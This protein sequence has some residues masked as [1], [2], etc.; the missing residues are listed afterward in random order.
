MD[1]KVELFVPCFIDQLYP[2][3]A[4]NTI[5][6]LERVGCEVIYNSEQTC[7][8]QP[9][10]NAGF[11]DEAKEVG[12][13]FL[14]KFTEENYIVAPSA[15]CVG[16][17]KKGYNDLFT[18]SIEHNRCRNIQRHVYEISDFLVNVIKRDY[19]G[20][21]LVGTAVY[22]DSC[23]ALRDCGIK[24]EPRKLLAQVGGLELVEMKGQET[25]CGFGGTFAVK[26]EGISTAMAEQKV[27]NAQAVNADYIIS[28][29]ASCL[30]QLQAYIDKHHIPIKTMHLVD[31]LTSGWAN[32]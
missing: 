4:F 28:T 16:M 24:E 32:I 20:A 10:Y 13:N 30:L 18:N 31:V 27:Q 19:F 17:L 2:D 11:W 22:H 12:S 26:F 3:T 15:S 21:E 25:C 7:C 6:L 1:K 8:G 29:D 23:S 14:K 5:Q 9:A